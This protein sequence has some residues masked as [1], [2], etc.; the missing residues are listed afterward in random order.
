MNS[1]SYPDLFL[2]LKGGNNNFGIVT[3]FDLKTFAN[4]NS[5]GYGGVLAYPIS[6]LDANLQ[7]YSALS[8]NQDPLASFS[9]GVYYT[10]GSWIVTNNVFYTKP[11]STKWSGYAAITPQYENTLRI[12]NVSSLAAEAGAAGPTLRYVTIIHV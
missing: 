2:A 5:L 4:G 1:G 3:R 9:T 8:P 7:V 6:T 11:D 12:A 10:G